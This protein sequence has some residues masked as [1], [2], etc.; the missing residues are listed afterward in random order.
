[1]VEMCNYLLLE[2][3]KKFRK[4]DEEVFSEIY[5]EFKKLIR[6]YSSRLGGED[7]DQELTVFFVELLHTV[8]LHKFKPDNSDGVSRYIA[9]SLRNKYIALSKKSQLECIMNTSFEE[10]ENF[11][12]FTTDDYSSISEALSHLSER[13][14]LIITYKYIY[15]Y[16]D[17]E[18]SEIL[19]I[20]RQAVNRLKNRA[21]KILE[22]FYRI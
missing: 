9:V 8:D 5:D 16:T 6:M 1:M 22:E 19:G 2:L 13:Q 21:I 3:I 18:I 10:A 7:S 20:T 14:Q 15:N 11:I 12:S 17:S 4:Q